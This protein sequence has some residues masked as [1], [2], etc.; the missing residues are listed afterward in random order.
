LQALTAQ[1][2]T[3]PCRAIREFLEQN[4][5]LNFSAVSG[6]NL[7]GQNFVAFR[8]HSMVLAQIGGPE[9]DGGA[10]ANVADDRGAPP[11][12]HCWRSI[13]SSSRRTIPAGDAE[14]R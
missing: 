11:R 9:A 6:G 3:P 7:L 14:W 8:V 10:G 12:L 2:R 4:L 13:W 1:G 5:E